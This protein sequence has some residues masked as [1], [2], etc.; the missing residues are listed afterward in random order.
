MDNITRFLSKVEKLESGCW[1]WRGSYFKKQYGDRPQFWMNGT[2]QIA[3]RCSWQLFRGPI[4]E[5]LMICH[6]VPCS[7]EWCVNPEHLY[8]GN[9]HSNMADRDA[10]GRT[11]RWKHRYNF[12]QTDALVEQV[13]ALRARGMKVA[14][15]CKT[16]SVSRSTV[17]RILGRS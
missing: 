3:A 17:Y 15:V 9:Q 8:P 16:A 6:T 13:K 14:D 4:P 2:A 10:A 1:L 5:C 11:S 12:V 7:H